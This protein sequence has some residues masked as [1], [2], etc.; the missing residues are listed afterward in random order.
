MN[1]GTFNIARSIWEHPVFR[2][3]KF[4][5]TQAFMWLVSE[6]SWKPRTIR[7]KTFVIELGRGE[8][9][10]SLRFMANKWQWKHDAV[11]RFLLRLE[12]HDMIRVSNATGQNVVSICNYDEYQ[13]KPKSTT[14]VSATPTAT[15]PRQD[16]HKEEED[17][18]KVNKIT[19][20]HFDLFWALWPNKSAK[21]PAIAAW[22]RLSLQD[23]ELVISLPSA[24]FDKWRAS[25]PHANPIHPA[26][27]L[28]N[29]RWEDE[30]SPQTNGTPSQA[31]M[32]RNMK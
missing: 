30:S 20:V 21:K 10:H 25:A 28:N 24:G 5:D 8:L 4:T 27:F 11:K 31:D 7:D 19:K 17:L 12:K 26:T 2:P 14:T 6:A 9:T 1:G 18:N 32:Y 16:R 22:N 29:K 13:A 15:G 23:Q 3:A